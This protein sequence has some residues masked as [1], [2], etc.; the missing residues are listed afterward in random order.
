MTGAVMRATAVSIALLCAAAATEAPDARQ[1]LPI[2]CP[3]ILSDPSVVLPAWQP[4]SDAPHG[5]HA[6]DHSVV[7]ELPP[8]LTSLEAEVW[9]GGGGGGG[10]TDD[11]LTDGGS[12][13]GGGASGGY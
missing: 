3:D 2:D 9:G 13:G 6:F 8:T 12:G 4:P 10:G 1:P 7:L 11:S 5:V